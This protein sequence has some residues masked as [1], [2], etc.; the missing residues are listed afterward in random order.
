MRRLDAHMPAKPEEKP[1]TINPYSRPK[2]EQLSKKQ[3]H[4]CQAN[5]QEKPT[6]EYQFPNRQILKLPFRR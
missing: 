3:V 1:T 2:E 6:E 5:C 4:F